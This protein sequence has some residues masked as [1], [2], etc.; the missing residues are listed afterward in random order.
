VAEELAIGIDIGATNTKIG[1]VCRGAS[2]RIIDHEQ[3]P[4]DL[5][6]DNPAPFLSA[7]SE[8]IERIIGQ[9]PIQRIGISLCSLINADHSGAFLSVNAPALNHLNIKAVFEERFGCP[10]QVM[11]DVNAYSLAEYTLGAGRGAQRLLCLALGTGL[12]IACI[13]QGRLIETWA[14]VP[15]DAARIILD[16]AAEV[17]CNGGV[18][19]SAEALCGTANITR[20]A[21]MRYGKDAFTPREVITAS[22][23]GDPLAGQVMAEIGGHV[24][25]LLALLSPIFFPQ[26]I[27]LTGGTSEAGEPLLR[28]VRERYAALIGDYMANLALTETGAAMRVEICKG[29]LGPEAAVIGAVL[30]GAP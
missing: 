23:A 25:H 21:K 1:L 17:M 3:L 19:G 4:T 13:N 24:G 5:R 15:A 8:I 27:L 9:E 26:R 18:R 12:A 10:V 7:L 29:A 28:A 30:P 14:G 6:N 16:P 22:R 11:N 2:T 20:L